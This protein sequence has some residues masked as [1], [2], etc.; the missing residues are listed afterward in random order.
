MVEL[1]GRGSATDVTSL[2]ILGYFYVKILPSRTNLASKSVKQVTM[3]NS[4]SAVYYGIYLMIPIMRPRP[5]DLARTVLV[6]S[7]QLL[8]GATL[9][10]NKTLQAFKFD[11]HEVLG[12][13]FDQLDGEKPYVSA[14]NSQRH[15]SRKYRVEGSIMGRHNIQTSFRLYT[16]TPI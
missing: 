12:P 14:L 8:V 10:L 16:Y 13:S 1:S 5:G 7:L 9:E 11:S 4:R 15:V 2:S 6:H 3:H